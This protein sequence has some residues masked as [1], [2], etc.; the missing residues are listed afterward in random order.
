MGGGRLLE[1]CCFLNPRESREEMAAGKSVI[2]SLDLTM[3]YTT[4]KSGRKMNRERDRSWQQP[5]RCQWLAALPG[6]GGRGVEGRQRHQW[7]TPRA[8]RG[9]PPAG[10]AHHCPAATSTQQQEHA[11]LPVSLPGAG[12]ELHEA[13]C[14]GPGT[15]QGQL[16]PMNGREKEMARRELRRA[17]QKRCRER[18]Q[19]VVRRCC[20]RQGDTELGTGRAAPSPAW[21]GRA[22]GAR[23][24]A[25]GVCRNFHIRR[26][27]RG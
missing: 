3:V 9:Q 27:C 24:S 11:A 25:R 10:A 17:H 18:L 6:G 12:S 19:P 21:T 26:S 23:R 15:A 5:L 16:V 14:L 4:L 1:G 22:G 7:K 8:A 2:S 20:A 13:S